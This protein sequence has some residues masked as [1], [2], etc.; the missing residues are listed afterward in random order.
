MAV[1]NFEHQEYSRGFTI[2]PE[3][4]NMM[5]KNISEETPVLQFLK[6]TLPPPTLRQ[7]IKQ[8]ILKYSG[9]EFI[10]NWIGKYR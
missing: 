1:H 5:I 3:Y 6:D 2:T 7:K 10:R 8:K 4:T 9:I